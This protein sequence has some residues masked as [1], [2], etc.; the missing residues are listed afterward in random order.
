M[1][2]DDKDDS[3]F[4]LVTGVGPKWR[5]QG[6]VRCMFG[7]KKE[8]FHDR[9]PPYGGS[10]GRPAYWVEQKHLNRDLKKL[11]ERYRK[12]FVLS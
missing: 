7:K 5:I 9:P 4:V 6:F 2:D 11:R 12:A 10:T 8:W 3:I 1:H